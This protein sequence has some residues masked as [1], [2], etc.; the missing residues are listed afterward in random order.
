M[1]A[2]RSSADSG[3]PSRSTRPASAGR[4]PPRHSKSV[5]LPEPLGPMRPSTSTGRI[6]K[7]TSLS[8]VRRPFLIV[9]AATL[10]TKV[11]MYEHL[12]STTS[13]R[14]DELVYWPA[15]VL[16]LGAAFFTYLS[17]QFNRSA[18]T[19]NSVSLAA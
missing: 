8:P 2:A 11:P 5:V 16:V 1:V 15:V 17:N 3:R 10:S 4:T 12:C 13:R 14:R 7:D 19:C 6:E 18:S 9:S